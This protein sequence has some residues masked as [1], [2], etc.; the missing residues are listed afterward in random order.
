MCPDTLYT[1]AR[2]WNWHDRA[3]RRDYEALQR[4]DREAVRRRARMLNRAREAGELMVLRGTE[5][6][7]K[8]EIGKTADA[9]NAVKTGIDIWRQAEGLP[10]WV[11]QIIGAE[12]HELE[13]IVADLDARRRAA[14]GAGAPDAG[15]TP[16]DPE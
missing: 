4:A 1:W 15:G 9:I 10:A 12:D 8:K 2:R 6:L 16:P 7:H 5:H 14:L 13:T 11:G 3:D